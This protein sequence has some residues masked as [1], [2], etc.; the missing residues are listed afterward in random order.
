ML[1]DLLEPTPARRIDAEATKLAISLAFAAG[2]SGGLF[3]DALDKATVPHSSWEPRSFASDLFL[4]QF[5]S[6][7][8]KI[9]IDGHEY[10]VLGRHL[11]KLLGYPPS[12]LAVIEWR[13]R[14]ARELSQEPALRK[15]LERLYL[16]LCR[17]RTVLEGSTGAGKWDSNRRQIDVLVLVK[18]IF[19]SMAGFA[20]ARSG[21]SRL[22]AFGKRVQSG[23][24][25]RSLA[26]LL[27]Y[28]ERLASLKLEV[29]VGADGRIRG[30][31]ILA[32][33]ED[34]ANPFVGSPLRRWF[35]KIELFLRGFKF[36][37]GEVMA[38]LVDAVFVGIEDEIVPLVQLIGDVEFYLGALG[39]VDIAKEAGLAMSLPNLVGPDAPRRLE[40][41]FNPLLLV[42]GIKPVPCDIRTDR[43]AT[44]VLVTGPNSGGKTRLLQSLGLTQLLAQSGLFVPARSAD[45]ALSPGLVMSLIEE[46]KP[47]Q[48]E[49]R[50]GTELVRIR[51]LFERLPPG[52]DGHPRRALL[53]NESVGGRRD[54]RARRAHARKAVAAGVHHDPLS[55]VRGAPRARSRHSRSALPP[56]G[57]RR[58]ATAHVSIHARRRHDLARRSRGG[59]AR[60][61]ARRAALAHPTEH[62]P[63]GEVAE[64]SFLTTSKMD[65][66]LAARIEESVRGKGKSQLPRLIARV[67]VVVLLVS[68][69]V[70]FGRARARDRA[71]VGEARAALLASMKGRSVSDHGRKIVDRVESAVMGWSRVDGEVVS[72]R[73]PALDALLKSPAIW[74][75]GPIALFP[76]PRRLAEGSQKDALLVCL[77]DPPAARTEKD[78][79]DRM[80]LAY[81]QELEPRTSNVRRCRRRSWGCPSSPPSSRSARR[82]RPT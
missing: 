9:R 3:T 80:R 71:L 44:T 45:V 67:L 55:P 8:F 72:A 24:P 7:C 36:S 21:L 42:H 52:G 16:L 64:V 46:A 10:P 34:Q 20:L 81:G 33:N 5:V 19:D 53:R 29:R 2:V 59:A 22:G 51:G 61:H 12:D 58:G 23:E 68:A 35:G 32:V 27:R 31:D 49:G 43:Q 26:D 50:L 60:R 28:D 1:P 79:Y 73:G 74:L 82:P 75:R 76:S 39:L 65:P 4:A 11:L 56:G 69:A 41:L 40:G 62:A 17:L 6:L 18:D 78:L 37:D 38:R 54:L 77:L 14:I 63:R 30:F 13:R 25:Y 48:S 57:A 70:S 66:A 15:E 47:D